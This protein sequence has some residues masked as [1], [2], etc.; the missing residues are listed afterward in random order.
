MGNV[1][2]YFYIYIDYSYQICCIYI[3]I[4]L[5]Y[6]PS[7]FNKPTISWIFESAEK[8]NRRWPPLPPA[9]TVQL[10]LVGHEFFRRQKGPTFPEVRMFLLYPQKKVGN[11]VCVYIYIYI[12]CGHC[13]RV[14]ATHD[15]YS[16][17]NIFYVS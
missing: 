8:H 13:Y 2:I 9:E 17:S 3:Y 6:N 7:S 14:G 10:L 11:V 12:G 5:F 16:Y 15:I 4:V 1:Y